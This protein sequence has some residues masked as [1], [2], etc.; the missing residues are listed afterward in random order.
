MDNNKKFWW[1]LVL[2]FDKYVFP[3]KIRTRYDRKRQEEGK[4]SLLEEVIARVM[5]LVMVFAIIWGLVL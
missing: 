3:S 4:Y 2:L 5:F 1:I